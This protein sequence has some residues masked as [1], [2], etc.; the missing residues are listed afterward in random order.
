MAL[1][2]GELARKIVHMG[3]GTDRLLPALP[4]PPLGG[5]PGRRRPRLQPLPA[6]AHRRPQALAASTRWTSGASIGII[7]YPLAVLLLVL[8]FWQRSGGRGGGLGDP[9]LRRRHGLGRR[10]VARPA[11]SSPGTRAKSWMGSLAYVLFGTLAAAV[12]L[13]WTAP[14]RYSASA[15]FALAAA[16]P[17][18]C[19]PPRSNRSPRGWTTT[20]ACRCVSGALPASASCSPRGAGA[21]SSPTP[22]CRCGSLLA[23]AVNAR[24]RRPGLRGAHGEPL[25]R[26]RRLPGRVR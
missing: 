8:V 13:V 2:R 17:P 10:H 21:P 23:A 3:V 25:G 16:S 26:R 7:L 6:A 24:A 5:D 22:A 12:L 20:S 1:T 11:A 19:S 14:G 15:G 4:G 18:P 9:R